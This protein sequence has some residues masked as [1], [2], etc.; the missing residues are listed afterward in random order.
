MKGVDRIHRPGLERNATV[1]ITNQQAKWHLAIY[2]LRK[3]Q[4]AI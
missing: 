3:S 4:S 2:D 1:S